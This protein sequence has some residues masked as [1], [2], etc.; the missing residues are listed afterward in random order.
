MQQRAP[1]SYHRLLAILIVCGLLISGCASIPG[2]STNDAS[3][4][5]TQ[6]ILSDDGVSELMTPATWTVRP[7]FGPDAA[8][9]VAEANGEAFLI[10]N[11]YFP[12]EIETTPIAEFSKSY[13]KGLTDSLRNAATSRGQSLSIN[14]APAH[15][16]V[17]T[18]NIGDVRL[19]YVSTVISGSAAMH[20]LIGWVAASN[21]SGDDDVLNRVVA[22]FHESASPR[23][24]RQRVSLEFAWP[25]SLQSA[26][27]FEQKS[28]K[29]GRP[30]EIKA[31]YLTTVRPG[32]ADELVISTRV[33]RQT[34]SNDDNQKQNDYVSALLNQASSEIPDYVV[35]REGEFLRVDNLS[36]YQQ[37]VEKAVIA[38][39]PA[40]LESEKDQIL[41]L[42]KPTL[43]EQ[44]L[45]AAV[46]DDWNKTVGSWVSSSYVV[47]Q[48][49]RFNEEYYA[50]A[51]GD[52]PFA[53]AVSRRIAGF[54]PCATGERQCVKL[55]LTATVAGEDFRSAMADFLER[56]AGQPVNVKHISV[57]KKMEII[58]E[59]DTL[60][61]HRSRAS[62]ETTVTIEDRKGNSRTSRD[63]KDTR[64]TYSYESYRASL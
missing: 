62:E 43:S 35:S 16:Y 24:A 39:L 47:G 3:T 52:T 63:T 20:H 4:A 18:G 17:V 59:P 37:R 1:H 34:V 19:T 5:L 58:A 48:T 2:S 56:T 61:P 55:V 6:S 31:T 30:S 28:V 50:P 45:A 33:M 51:L 7:D 9:R 49:Y 11:T 57:V 53:M 42:V 25:D 41:A 44:F 29:R 36:G 23:P 46:T 10:V 13:A 15:R 40:E 38:N 64:V 60:I 27:N 22:S 32:N 12:G 26:V 21:Y 8:I 14:G 54:T